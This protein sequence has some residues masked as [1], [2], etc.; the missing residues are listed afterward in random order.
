MKL[1]W[2]MITINQHKD[3]SVNEEIRRIFIKV[4]TMIQKLS[5]LK[6]ILSSIDIK[7]TS[8]SSD[9]PIHS[10]IKWLGWLLK[11]NLF[12]LKGVNLHSHQRQCSSVILQKTAAILATT[13]AIFILINTELFK[14]NANGRVFS[15]C[16]INSSRKENFSSRNSYA[17]ACYINK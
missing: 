3:M 12:N 15:F 14:S 1:A 16:M 8:N 9:F 2:N 10:K 11:G 13:W 17:A 5:I 4:L 6:S 7:W